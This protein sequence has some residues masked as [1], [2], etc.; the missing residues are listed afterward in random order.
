MKITPFFLLFLFVSFSIQAEVVDLRTYQSSVKDQGDRNTC[1]YFAVTAM[2]ESFIKTRFDKEYDL[3]EEFQIY[4]GKAH[5]KEYADKEFGSTYEIALNVRNQGFVMYEQ[6]VPYQPSAFTTNPICSGFDPFDTQAPAICFAGGPYEWRDQKR[7]RVDGLEV[8]WITGLWSFGKSRSQLIMDEL[9]KGHPVVLTL[10][11]YPE[12]WE[13]ELVEYTEEID[14][15]CTEGVYEC[16]GHAILLTGYDSEKEEFF[17]K[18]SWGTNWGD[19]GYGRAS[20]EYIDKFSDMPITFRW[21]RIMADIR[22]YN[23]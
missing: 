15:L 21:S 8:N 6:Q 11:V 1:A 2:V 14:Q 10:K 16:A 3:S 17:F 22:E 20:F 18:N 5:Y 12:T 13:Q 4:Y 19:Q 7:L 9:K 23:P